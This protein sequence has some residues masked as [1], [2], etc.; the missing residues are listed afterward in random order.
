[1]RRVSLEQVIVSR[2]TETLLEE[3]ISY[4]R[5][6]HTLVERWGFGK[7]EERGFG[8]T[9]LFC[10]PPGTGKT[11]AASAVATA[12]GLELYRVDLS[13]LVSKYIGETE[14]HLASVFDI[15]E[16]GEIMLLFDEADSVFG[17][18]TE[19]KSSV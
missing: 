10:G 11:F 14:K 8:A 17:K 6:R 7:G 9:G 15:A 19:V 3:F 13:Q 2:D 5:H 12:L 1:L 18:R 4:T 16:S